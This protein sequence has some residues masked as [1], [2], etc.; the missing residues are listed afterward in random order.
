[1]GRP[2][3]WALLA[4]PFPL[5]IE[6]I[7]DKPIDPRPEQAVEHAANRNDPHDDAQGLFGRVEIHK[8]TQMFDGLPTCDARF[9]A[10]D[11]H[12]FCHSFIY[13]FDKCFQS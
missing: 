5:L 6:A 3:A 12:G 1:M 7:S 13:R 8:L 4:L 11:F 2:T 10:A 9:L